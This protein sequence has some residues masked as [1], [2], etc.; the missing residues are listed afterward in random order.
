MPRHPAVAYLCLVRPQ[1]FSLVSFFLSSKRLSFREW[2]SDDALFAMSLW[3]NPLVTAHIGGPFSPEQAR[4]RLQREI[5]LGT[6]SGLQYW[7]VFLTSGGTFVGC[8]GLRPYR[9]AQQVLEL[10]FY[11]LPLHCGHGLATEAAHAV[12]SHAFSTLGA[13]GLF[14]GHHPGNAASERVLRRLGFR[15]THDEHYEPTG[16]M[17]PSYMLRPGEYV[18]PESSG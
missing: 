8:C 12:I 14:A 16:L 5:E 18:A 6:V 1:P 10:G 15:Y 4:Q 11:L 9:P 7:P 13:Q 3:C 2:S 17:H